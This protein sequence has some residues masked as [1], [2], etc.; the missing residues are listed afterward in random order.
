ME[1]LKMVINNTHAHDNAPKK[2]G[3]APN[4]H[5]AL[6]DVTDRRIMSAFANPGT[7]NEALAQLANDFADAMEIDLWR[8]AIRGLIDRGVLI[9]VHTDGGEVTYAV[10]ASELGRIDPR[11]TS[12]LNRLYTAELEESAN[13]V[14]HAHELW[15]VAKMKPGA[16]TAVLDSYRALGKAVDSHNHRVAQLARR[17][18]IDIAQVPTRQ[19]R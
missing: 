17:R 7:V 18:G 9:P 12:T 5:P 4:R 2:R 6:V 1:P 11:E 15:R 8:G 3:K 14:R 19:L 16:Y 10:N 13:T